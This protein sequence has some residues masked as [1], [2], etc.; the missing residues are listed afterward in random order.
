MNSNNEWISTT[1]N[2]NFHLDVYPSGQ[3]SKIQGL[4]H[5]LLRGFESHHVYFLFF[6]FFNTKENLKKRLSPYKFRFHPNIRFRQFYQKSISKA[7]MNQPYLIYNTIPYMTM[8]VEHLTIRNRLHRCFEQYN[9]DII[10][11]LPF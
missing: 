6:N 8:Q 4:M 3:R 2:L 11:Q 7:P 5:Q 10:F 9:L 1:I